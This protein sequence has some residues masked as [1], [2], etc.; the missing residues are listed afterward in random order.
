MGG[1]HMS[2]RSLKGK[3]KFILSLCKRATIRMKACESCSLNESK[4]FKL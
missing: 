2:L 1:V 4:N 3:Q